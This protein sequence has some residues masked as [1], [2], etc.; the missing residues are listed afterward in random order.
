MTRTI[1][2]C[3]LICAATLVVVIA[4]CRPEWL[5]DTND[6]LHN[7]VNHELLGLLGIIMTI[8]LAS[9]ASLHLEFNKIEERF[10]QRG[11]KKTRH[12]VT[13]DAFCL[14]GLFFISVLIVVIKP[15]VGHGEVA[16]A[17]FNG[18]ALVILLW[19][20][21]ILVEITQLAF[22]IQPDIKD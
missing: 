13:Q 1:A 7:F 14:I 4:A 3:A 16:E 20:I 22:A 11:L 10:K 21:L 18:A 12:G 6:F 5:S 17:V 15:I 9:A 2:I 8:T 19:N